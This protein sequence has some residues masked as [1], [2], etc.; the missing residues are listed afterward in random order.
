[1]DLDALDR[2]INDACSSSPQSTMR[3]TTRRR[4]LSPSSKRKLTYMNTSSK[5]LPCLPADV[6]PPLPPPLVASGKKSSSC[7]LFRSSLEVFLKIIL[8]GAMVKFIKPDFCLTQSHS[9]GQSR[10]LR[11]NNVLLND[12]AFRPRFIDEIYHKGNDGSDEEEDSRI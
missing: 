2:L 6:V 12:S 10:F 1:M 9:H 4:S 3:R 8:L 7:D 5:S 11:G